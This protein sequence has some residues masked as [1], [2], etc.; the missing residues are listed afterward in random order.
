RTAADGTVVAQTSADAQGRFSAALPEGT[1]RVQTL[2]RGHAPATRTV[3]LPPN[4]VKVDGSLA[5]SRI[6]A[7]IAGTTD[8]PAD[9]GPA[10][11]RTDTLLGTTYGY[12]ANGKVSASIVPTVAGNNGAGAAQPGWLADLTI[13]DGTASE[14]LDWSEHVLTTAQPGAPDWNRS[15]EWLG[16]PQITA[17]G[18]T[19]T[20]SGS[21]QIDPNLKAKLSYRALPD[22]PVVEMTLELTNTGTTGFTGFYQYIIDPDSPV[23]SNDVTRV[24]GLANNNPGYVR[25]GWTA[26]YLYDG[27]LTTATGGPAQGLAWPAAQPP[28]ALS[29]QG[30]VAGLWFDASVAAGGTRTIRWY[31]I[32]DYP[33][34]GTDPTA[35]IAAW[36]ARVA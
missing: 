26:N 17:A 33:A 30:Y 19:V 10:S 8:L 16:L 24:P 5:L 6:T 20:A 27:P 31:H 14:F 9:Y 29:A 25:S 15:G 18:D 1:Y 4:G 2:V 36:A 12:V 13:A 32:T 22:A 34:S 28:V 21:A 7:P 23:G 3:D 35:A 11:T